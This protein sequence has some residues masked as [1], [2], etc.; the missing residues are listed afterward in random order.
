MAGWPWLESA[1]DAISELAWPLPRVV[2]AL[3]DI[4]VALPP[5]SAPAPSQS[6]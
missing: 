6:L 2:A 5:L 1:G 3:S 4:E